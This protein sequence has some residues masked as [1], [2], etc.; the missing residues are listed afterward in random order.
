MEKRVERTIEF[1]P[2]YFGGSDNDKSNTFI[3][4]DMPIQRV[5]KTFTSKK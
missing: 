5:N 3:E 4:D 1:T 2:P